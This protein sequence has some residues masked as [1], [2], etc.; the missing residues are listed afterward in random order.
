V[1]R[2]RLLEGEGNVD[3]PE[4]LFW[5][6]GFVVEADDAAFGDGLAVVEGEVH[7]AVADP[8]EV[9]VVSVRRCGRGDAGGNW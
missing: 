1:L 5:G 4:V 3:G 8:E 7:S 2:V 9:P 6:D